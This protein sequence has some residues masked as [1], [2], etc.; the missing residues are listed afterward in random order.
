[1]KPKRKKNIA[2]GGVALASAAVLST[3]AILLLVPD[4]APHDG[5]A[6][7]RWEL[8]AGL[9]VMPMAFLLGA[10][11]LCALVCWVSDRSRSGPFV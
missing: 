8:G 2:L 3:A 1:M 7:W 5:F 6:R 4:W 9:I 11:A 10:T